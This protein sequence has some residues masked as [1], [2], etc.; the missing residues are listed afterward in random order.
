[1]TLR[2]ICLVLML[3]PL[4]ALLLHRLPFLDLSAEHRDTVLDMAQ[5]QRFSEIR[6]MPMFVDFLLNA[7]ALRRVMPQRM[8]NGAMKTAFWLNVYNTLVRG[9][10][11]AAA[12]TKRTC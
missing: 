8:E 4:P 7:H 6:R 10:I 12:C 5:Q 2:C 9:P 11:V 1:M 3:Y